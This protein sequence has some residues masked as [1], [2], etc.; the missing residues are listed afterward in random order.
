[1]GGDQPI[2]AKIE[3]RISHEELRRIVSEA[4]GVMVA[5]G[6]LGVQIPLEE[7]PSVQKAIIRLCNE[8]GKPV[9]TATQMLESMTRNPRPTRAEVTDVAAAILDGTDAVM[10]SGET[11]VGRYPVAAIRM[12]ARIAERTEETVDFEGLLRNRRVGPGSTVAEAVSHAAC[13]ASHDLQVAAIVS[14]T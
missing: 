2:I 3:T 7:V 12:M 4:D 1:A 9:I 10:L 5:R 11:A 14:S 8:A 13:Q 6:D